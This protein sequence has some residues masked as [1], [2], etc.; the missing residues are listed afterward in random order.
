M[1]G[2]YLVCFAQLCL[3]RLVF[4]G[5]RKQYFVESCRPSCFG[6]VF[7]RAPFRFLTWCK[8]QWPAAFGLKHKRCF[9]LKSKRQYHE[10]FHQ[11]LLKTCFAIWSRVA[12]KPRPSACRLLA[13][14]IPVNS[15]H[16]SRATTAIKCRPVVRVPPNCK[17]Q[18]GVL[19]ARLNPANS[20][21]HAALV[22]P[23][24]FKRRRLLSLA[25]KRKA[26]QHQRAQSLP[27]VA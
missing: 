13:S 5:E 7:G 2:Y 24:A 17:N 27:T 11:R 23:K 6:C 16:A 18:R 9:Y 21:T 4:V 22:R 14:Q 19:Q 15:Q 25:G 26:V 1:Y 8:D 3:P 12:A 10:S 20:R